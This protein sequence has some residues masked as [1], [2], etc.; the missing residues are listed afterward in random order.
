[1]NFRDLATLSVQ[2]LRLFCLFNASGFIN[3]EY[4]GKKVL[5][6]VF[7]WLF[8]ERGKAIKERK[9]RSVF[10]VPIM[11]VLCHFYS[12]IVLYFFLLYYEN[13]SN[14]SSRMMKHDVR[15][16]TLLSRLKSEIRKNKK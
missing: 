9:S 6:N 16:H 12:Y 14:E 2:F 7:K 8:G 15:F 13:I 10:N 4:F 3:Y 1:M 11:N 5:L